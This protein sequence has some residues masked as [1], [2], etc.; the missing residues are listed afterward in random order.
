MCQSKVRIPNGKRLRRRRTY[1]EKP[2]V[3]NNNIQSQ[4]TSQSESDDSCAGEFEEGSEVSPHPWLVP[5]VI[6]L[7][8][9]AKSVE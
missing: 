8:A 4:K 3:P 1:A 6:S 2:T 5:L 7:K 9:P